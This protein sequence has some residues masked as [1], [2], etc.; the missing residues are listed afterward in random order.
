MFRALL[1]ISGT[2]KYDGFPIANGFHF[3]RYFYVKHDKNIVSFET[4]FPA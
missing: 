1:F 4:L 3:C 2:T